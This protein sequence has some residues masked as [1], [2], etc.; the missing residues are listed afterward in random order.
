MSYQQQMQKALNSV[1]DMAGASIQ[2]SVTHQGVDKSGLLHVSDCLSEAYSKTN[3]KHGFS[4]EL[5]A[6]VM[7]WIAS[8]ELV[9]ALNKS[10]KCVVMSAE[11]GEQN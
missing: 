8:K 7:L 5:F 10:G 2:F 4:R 11:D 9:D 3:A 1:A 6:M